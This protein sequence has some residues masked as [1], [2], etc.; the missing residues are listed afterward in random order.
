MSTQAI[1][2]HPG[3][4]TATPRQS[5]YSAP[6]QPI[7]SNQSSH[8]AKLKLFETGSERDRPD[9]RR[10]LTLKNLIKPIARGIACTT[11]RA[12]TVYLGMLLIMRM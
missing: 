7:S 6:K 1:R 5:Y 9:Y 10:Y 8:L 11:A 2:C 4:E 3:Q 12:L